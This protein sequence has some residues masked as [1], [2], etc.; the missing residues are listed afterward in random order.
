MN[1][2]PNQT[3]KKFILCALLF[4]IFQ[5]GCSQESSPYDELIDHKYYAY[6]VPDD[7]LS[8][9]DWILDT[10]IKENEGQWD[11]HCEGGISAPDAPLL[12]FYFDDSSELQLTISIS[13]RG[14]AWNHN[15]PTENVRLDIP[16]AP[17]RT[18]IVY[19]GEPYS[20][21][22][23]E[24]IFGN[25]VIVRGDQTIDEK[26]HIINRLEYIGLPRDKQINPW[27][28]EWC[29]KNRRDW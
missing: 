1:V 20:S 13:S 27:S 14:A 6:I 15:N 8:E 25:K 22:R 18:G 5:F 3:G 28:A 7:V 12:L 10:P 11:I 2:S 26:I 24:D 19:K 23:F 4:L 16:W 29:E 21:I 9:R 17:E